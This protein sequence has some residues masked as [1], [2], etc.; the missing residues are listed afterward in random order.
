MNDALCALCSGELVERPVMLVR[1]LPPQGTVLIRDVP[2]RVCSQCG[3][4]WLSQDILRKLQ[5]VAEGRRSPQ[6]T[7][8]VPVYALA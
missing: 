7:Q 8:R 3:H 6:E 2:A 4:R 1:D 5:D